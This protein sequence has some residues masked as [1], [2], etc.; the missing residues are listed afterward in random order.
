MSG[1]NKNKINLQ[2]MCKFLFTQILQKHYFWSFDIY[3]I[4]LLKPI[5]LPVQSYRL[6]PWC[7]RAYFLTHSLAVTSY[8]CLSVLQ[9]RAI[10]G[11]RGSSGLGSQSKEQ[12]E[13]N[14]EIQ[15]KINLLSLLNNPNVCS[16]LLSSHFTL[17]L[18]LS[19][20]VF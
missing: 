15:Q 19:L 3:F 9:I 13:S 7:Q 14:T 5:T 18:I 16:W 17:V 20:S 6:N 12:M 1:Q 2:Y 8:F 4:L 11:T 10:S